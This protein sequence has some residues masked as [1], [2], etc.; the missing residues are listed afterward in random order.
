[1]LVAGAAPNIPVGAELF[2][3]NGLLAGAA[4]AGCAVP[5]GEL[6]VPLADGVEPNTKEAGLADLLSLP[7][8]KGVGVDLGVDEVVPKLNEAGAADCDEGLFV[9]VTPNVLEEL[10]PSVALASALTPNKPVDVL[11]GVEAP[12]FGFEP[13]NENA[14]ALVGVGV[15]VLA[16]AGILVPKVNPLETGAP[17]I[18][19]LSG[20]RLVGMEGTAADDWSVAL[21]TPPNN[22]L[23][24]GA[25]GFVLPK[26]PP[27]G[28]VGTELF[29]PNE[30]L[31][32]AIAVAGLSVG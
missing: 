16:L 18:V 19:S 1:V 32:A 9:P 2:A 14:G 21:L 25:V 27:E 23:D 24:V 17:N 13:P 29:V 15:V 8:A 4:K 5:N 11:A 22:G 28:K 10:D 6:A 3:P 30:K 20:F 26:S 7:N 31:G 12:V